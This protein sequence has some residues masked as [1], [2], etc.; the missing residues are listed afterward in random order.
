MGVI[1]TPIEEWDDSTVFE[2]ITLE[3][4][5]PETYTDYYQQFIMTKTIDIASYKNSKTLF[6]R[7]IRWKQENWDKLPERHAQ[8]SHS[9][10][11]LGDTWYS[12]S[13]VDGGVRPKKIVDNKGNWDYIHIDVSDEKYEKVKA[14]CIE[15]CRKAKI[16]R[17]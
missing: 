3:G 9:E 12:S 5:D 8:Y 17:D 10:V 7:L 4:G 1:K 15:E 2:S 13:E 16:R 6:G 14:F 11:K